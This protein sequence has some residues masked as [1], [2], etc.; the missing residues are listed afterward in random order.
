ASDLDLSSLGFSGGTID[1]APFA[2]IERT[3]ARANETL[4]AARTRAARID[5][6]ATLPPLADAIHELRGTVDEAATVIGSL[7]GAA[8]LLPS[9]LGADGPR[10]YVLAMQNNAEL[11]SS[12]GIIG[13]IALLRAE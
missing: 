10:N 13:A 8:A 11:R 9:M 2:E 7:H 4:S 6:D 12:G 1:L 3:L 5:A